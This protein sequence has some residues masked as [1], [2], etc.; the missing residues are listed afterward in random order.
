[1]DLIP[2]NGL[3]MIVEARG[4]RYTMIGH[5]TTLRRATGNKIK[6]MAVTIERKI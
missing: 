6:E 3:A 5:S 2:K 4:A 1:M